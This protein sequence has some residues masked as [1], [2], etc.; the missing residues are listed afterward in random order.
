MIKHK[1]FL[2]RIVAETVI[3]SIQIDLNTNSDYHLY[4][5]GTKVIVVLD[6]ELKIIITRLKHIF[7]NQNRNHYNNTF[8]LMRNKFVYSY[9]VKIHTLQFNEVLE[10]IFCLLLVVGMFS[11][12]KVV[13]WGAH[14]HP[15]LIHVNVWQNP[16]QYCKV[17]SLQLK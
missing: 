6:R 14:V 17:I 15:W 11:M 8:L 10:S 12:Q 3:P 13:E 7:I 5:V 4:Q 16:L 9:K 1:L 2:F